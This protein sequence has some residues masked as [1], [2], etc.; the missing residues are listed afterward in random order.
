MAWIAEW[1]AQHA[2]PRA[3][4]IDFFR[5]GLGGLMFVIMVSPFYMWLGAVHDNAYLPLPIAVIFAAQNLHMR[6][7]GGMVGYS[8]RV[9]VPVADPGAR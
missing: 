4:R 1:L 9:L 7:S 2:Q 3:V 5:C 6:F 8:S